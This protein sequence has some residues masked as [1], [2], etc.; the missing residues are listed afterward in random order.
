MNI[1]DLTAEQ[2]VIVL[3]Q[4]CAIFNIGD[5]AQATEILLTNIRN[6]QRRA[7]CLSRIESIHTDTIQDLEG[8]EHD[9]CLL[10]WS[11]TPDEYEK[12]YRCITGKS[13]HLS[14][15]EQQRTP[16]VIETP[17]LDSLLMVD[18]TLYTDEMVDVAHAYINQ[19][20]PQDNDHAGEIH[21]DISVIEN[22]RLLSEP[23][24]L[25]VA[26]DQM[27]RD[28]LESRE[29]FYNTFAKAIAPT[30][31]EIVLHTIDTS[32]QTEL[33]MIATRFVAGD[34]YDFAWALNQRYRLPVYML[35]TDIN[36]VPVPAH[37]FVLLPNG[38]ILDGC[39]VSTFAQVYQRSLTIVESWGI[40]SL[41]LHAVAKEVLN[42][43]E[44]SAIQSSDE[45]LEDFS[46]VLKV[47]GL[48]LD[49]LTS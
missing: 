11:D 35:K 41:D 28:Y 43:V 20:T 48:D 9:D 2:A 3:K 42:E 21:S 10:N 30:L 7:E 26:S 13:R 12:R 47:T 34:C 18:A 33:A 46:L 6:A 44:Y 27:R 17:V 4:I 8:D 22:T 39:G 25:A 23:L 15:F 1:N 32:Q 40:H 37:A 14:S 5:N 45:I 24:F 29:A 16:E 49:D 36:N 38:Y 19:I 31:P